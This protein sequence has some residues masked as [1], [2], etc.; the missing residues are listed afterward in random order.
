MKSAYVDTNVLLRYLTA[1]DPAH[2]PAA[3]VLLAEAEAGNLQLVLTETTV[4]EVVWVLQKAYGYSRAQIG[5]GL[6]SLILSEGMTGLDSDVCLVALDIFERQPLD[7]TDALL[8]AQALVRGPR[9]VYSFD[10]DFDRVRGVQ[11][12]EPGRAIP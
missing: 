9:A 5:D 12:L 8:A 4:A 6:R 10:R 2:S 3:T 11:R 1:D 7:F